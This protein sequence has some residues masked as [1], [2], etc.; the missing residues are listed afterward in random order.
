[1]V[2]WQPGISS[3]SPNRVDALVWVLTE[4][5]TG[6]GAVQAACVGW[7]PPERRS[8]WDDPRDEEHARPQIERPWLSI[9]ERDDYG[10]LFMG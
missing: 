10:K 3:W 7:D 4:L 6:E 9:W 8:I 5:I 1:M 2:S